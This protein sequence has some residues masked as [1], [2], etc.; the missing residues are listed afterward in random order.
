MAKGELRSMTGF[1]KAVGKYNDMPLTAEVRSVNSK[2]LDLSFRLP[3]AVRDRE[4]DLR[5]MA[6]ETIVRGKSDMSLRMEHGP[7]SRA[8]SIDREAFMANARMLKAL[9]DEA[10]INDADI[11]GTVLRL[12]DVAVAEEPTNA[13]EEMWAA[14]RQVMA[15][16]LADFDRFRLREGA[17]LAKELNDRVNR[18]LA[19]LAQTEPFEESRLATTRTRLVERMAEVGAKV[20]QNRF[21]QELIFYLEKLDVTEEKVRLRAHCAHFL[22]TMDEAQAGRKLGFI[23]QEMGREINTL[24]SKSN[25]A[26]M[27]RIVVEMKDELEKIKEQV[28]NVL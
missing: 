1:G 10:G 2:T 13:T 18:I 14:L 20:D 6:T 8:M 12:P 5:Q 28:L 21:E 26:D 16:A 17:A 11:L 23:A 24:G 3:S 27:Q 19:L 7:A 25:Q 4:G 15:D 22:H 9:A